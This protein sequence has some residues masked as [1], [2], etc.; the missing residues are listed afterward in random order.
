MPIIITLELIW[1]KYSYLTVFAQQ[2]QFRVQI[3]K[4]LI[5]SCSLISAKLC[6]PSVVLNIELLLYLR[7]LYIML[8]KLWKEKINQIWINNFCKMFTGSIN[9]VMHVSICVIHHFQQGH[10][11]GSR[12]K[13][14]GELVGKRG[15]KTG[16][17]RDNWKRKAYIR[18]ALSCFPCE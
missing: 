5:V 9:N 12:M 15:E 4:N 13:K 18:R 11:Q 16:N 1:I 3:F 10:S 8:W 2:R 17:E 14:R 7:I 6:A